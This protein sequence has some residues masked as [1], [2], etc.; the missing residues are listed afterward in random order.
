MVGNKGIGNYKST[1]I[2]SK[3]LG[4]SKITKQSQKYSQEKSLSRQYNRQDVTKTQ[5]GFY[6]LGGAII[7]E[8]HDEDHYGQGD[9]ETVNYIHSSQ[10]RNKIY[11]IRSP[12]SK[13]HPRKQKKNHMIRNTE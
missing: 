10:N 12:K 4:K 5:T 9:N 8:R 13:Q 7:P 6:V 11:N 3:S 2:A 1:N